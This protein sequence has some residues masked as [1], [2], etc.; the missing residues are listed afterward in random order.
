MGTI[1]AISAEAN[2]VQSALCGIE[3]AFA[4][5][6]QVDK[7]MHPTR[8]GGDLIA[9]HQGK[10]G[11]PVAWVSHHIVMTAHICG[12]KITGAQWPTKRAGVETRTAVSGADWLLRPGA[13]N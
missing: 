6:D 1:I 3:A 9:I 4:A 11:A 2:T 8:M 5:I 7:L 13:P 10:L 12:C